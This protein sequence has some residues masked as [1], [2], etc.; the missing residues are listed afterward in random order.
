MK[1][2]KNSKALFVICLMLC[3][4]CLVFASCG[5]KKNECKHENVTEKIVTE[6]GCETVGKKQTVCNDCNAMVSES[7]IEA[8]EHKWSFD[9]EGSTSA[10][11]EAEGANVFKCANCDKT[12]SEPVAKISHNY[13]ADSSL[14]VGATCTTDGKEVTKCSFCGITDEIETSA[15]G[16]K[17]ISEWTYTGKQTPKTGSSCVF[18]CERTAQCEYC[19]TVT[20]S[21]E[22][23][24]HNY[25][26][27]VKTEATCSV[28]G[29]KAYICTG[30]G[31]VQGDTTVSYTVDHSWDNGVVNNEYKLYSCSKCDATRKEF[32][33]TQATLKSDDLDSEIKLGD[34]VISMDSTASNKLG[35]DNATLSANG[36]SKN[37]IPSNT[38]GLD[39]VGDGDT[40]YNLTLTKKDGTLITD[41]GTGVVT[42][43]LPYTL[44]ADEDPASVT[45]FYLD[46]TDGVVII[47][48]AVYHDG[49]VTFETNHFS[50][51]MVGRY[52]VKEICAKYG[53]NWFVSERAATCTESG[54]N[55]TTCTR[56]R[57]K[58]E[59]YNPFIPALGHVESAPTSEKAAGCTEN[60]YKKYNCTRCTIDY[61]VIIY[62]T[63]HELEVSEKVDSTCTVAGYTK[64]ECKKCSE[65]K[66][67]YDEKLP[68]DFKTEIVDATCKDGGY[69]N[70]I[71][72]VCG[73][74]EKSNV[75][76]PLGHKWNIEAPTCGAGQICTV[77]GEN[78]A[79]ATGNHNMVSG[80]CS[81][82]GNG[83]EHNYTLSE[84]KV[85]NC[86]E[87]GYKK[88]TCSKCEGEKTEDITPALGHKYDGE[89]GKC[90]VCGEGGAVDTTF[91]ENIINSL[92]SG[93]QAF[94]V[95]DLTLY[96]KN[97]YTED[98]KVEI[99]SIV[100]MDFSR[101]VLSFKD[102][103]G[104]LYGKAD[105]KVS[106]NSGTTFESNG[107]EIYGDGTYLYINLT[108]ENDNMLY[109]YSYDHVSAE[110]TGEDASGLSGILSGLMSAL[111][112]SLF[113]K[114]NNMSPED[115]EAFCKFFDSVFNEIFVDK[116]D[117]T[118]ALNIEGL[119][120]LSDSLANDTVAIFIDKYFGEG[121]YQKL[122]DEVL[123][124][125][126][127]TI[128]DFYTMLIEYA[129][130]N[131]QTED[132]VVSMLEEAISTV[133]GSEI[134]IKEMLSDEE[135]AG[136]TIEAIIATMIE[137]MTGS[138]NQGQD[139]LPP[140]NQPMSSSEPTFNYTETMTSVFEML[141]Q[142]PLY[143]LILP[144]EFVKDVVCG[145]VDKLA[146]ESLFS[147]TLVTETSG[148][149][150]SFTVKFNDFET[151][152]GGSY[153]SVSTDETPTELK[154][155]HIVNITGELKFEPTA[156]IP[157]E[158][159][160]LKNA[161]EQTAN[162]I[163]NSIKDK[164][165]SGSITVLDA[166][167][168]SIGIFTK[169]PDGTLS[170]IIYDT[171]Y[172]GE[173]N[174]IPALDRVALEIP[175]ISLFGSI[176][177]VSNC[178]GAFSVYISG[179]AIDPNDGSKNWRTLTFFI[180]PNNGNITN[181]TQHSYVEYHPTDIPAGTP[182]SPDQVECED[183]WFTYEKCEL[184]GD[185]RKNQNYKSHEEVYTYILPSNFVNCEYD[186]YTVVVNCSA[187]GEHIHNYNTT[188]HWSEA[189]RKYY[190]YDTPHGTM[191][192]YQTKCPCGYLDSFE[193]RNYDEE[194]GCVIGGDTTDYQPI[195]SGDKEIGYSEKHHCAI[196]HE[197]IDGP[198]SQCSFYMIH[199]RY[200]PTEPE[201]SCIKTYRNVYTFYNNGVQVGEKV[202]T[203]D[204]YESH[205]YEGEPD[206]NT[207][208]HYK[209]TEN[210]KYCDA[211]YSLEC[212]Y[213][214]IGRLIYD[215]EKDFEHGRVVREYH[216]RYVYE[217]LTSCY[218]NSYYKNYLTMT[219]ERFY[220]EYERH[221]YTYQTIID[222][223]CTQAP[224]YYEGCEICGH[225]GVYSFRAPDGH[226][227]NQE[228][229]KY[230]CYRC[231]LESITANSYISMEDLT[232]D[233]T[234][235][236]INGKYVIGFYDYNEAPL[237]A[238]FTFVKKDGSKDIIIEDF[239]DWSFE[240]F[241]YNGEYY[242]TS[243]LLVISMEDVVKAAANKGISLDEYDFGIT[244]HHKDASPDQQQLFCTFVLTDLVY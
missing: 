229:D 175:D 73:H 227:W 5:N 185:V 179:Y 92:C 121:A 105:V 79:P 225:D 164:C 195:M 22:K 62:A 59:G 174:F 7:N 31:E 69:T 236:N 132:A 129:E 76:A 52:T 142:A 158:A 115:K 178:S 242:H 173:N 220:G 81:V 45:I 189:F 162:K 35:S 75:T 82:C 152:I 77:C 32:S 180:N 66:I 6:A 212:K 150:K 114:Y 148:A 83:C 235:G 216:Y 177:F 169:N 33:G 171:K 14:S 223:T 72:N 21:D 106:N 50:Y 87:G 60:G 134:N 93:E 96:A 151:V 125:G 168:N 47:D 226:Y 3:L 122:K 99:I 204:K 19:G 157:A 228:K 156:T 147:I 109:R 188:G 141:E 104:K 203:Y 55:L 84:E 146:D 90:S 186:E 2:F 108:S 100:K 113:D 85:A 239:I 200:Y 39:K 120:K 29:E 237:N 61:T 243:S 232:N 103:V 165:N 215:Y 63:G 12:K 25:V 91:V 23:S 218:C 102:G 98:N 40:V 230:V 194:N 140:Q 89:G 67:E 136:M 111:D 1:N 137:S 86:T 110:M 44:G 49:Y 71:C 183:Y 70:K 181:E 205:T 224:L 202:T 41:F 54:F 74:T 68:H 116:G 9:A 16:H 160:N 58:A 234:Y 198:Q 133:V 149:V 57:E 118:Y 197:G 145:I 170:L 233:S 119:K 56:C 139:S 221:E 214:E 15:T 42:V 182:I 206:I 94:T 124:A 17:M 37:E 191:T 36:L 192:V 211:S 78:G 155:H 28:P 196:G 187:C 199:E 43:K 240:N 53:H 201:T 97:K 46:P 26:F 127:K 65:S 126:T 208:T 138:D 163:W 193:Y 144:S 222:G 8:L 207:D 238:Y 51:Y 107:A 176:E 161:Y 34:T 244:L 64:T 159:E 154:I 38:P 112:G 209:I 219:E 11:C 130:A 131:G 153:G 213:D 172:S 210:C 88:Y 117:N 30:C 167:Y 4:V 123:V 10:T 13:V 27:G 217:S 80:V 95:S 48:G 18:L 241:E 135:F 184:C 24:I 101:A 190:T 231:G 166:Y 20:E 143:D 128:E